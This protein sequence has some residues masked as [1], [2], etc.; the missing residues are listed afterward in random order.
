[1]EPVHSPGQNRLYIAAT[2]TEA[3]VDVPAVT[4]GEDDADYG[5]E[6]IRIPFA[7]WLL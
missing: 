2:D 7:R 5:D 3:I 6:G 4:D 1:M